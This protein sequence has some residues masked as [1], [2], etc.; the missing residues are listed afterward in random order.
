MQ[1]WFHHLRRLLLRAAGMPYLPA[2]SRRQR[3]RPKVEALEERWVPS[4]CSLPSLYI[5]LPA[6]IGP[7]GTGASKG[8]TITITYDMVYAAALNQ[9]FGEYLKGLKGVNGAGGQLVLNPGSATNPDPNETTV[10]VQVSRHGSDIEL[11]LDRN[12]QLGQSPQYAVLK[13]VKA[14]L[15]PPKPPPKACPTHHGE[16]E[17]CRPQHFGFGVGGIGGIGF[18]GLGGFGGGGFGGAGLGNFGS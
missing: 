5:K 18:G 13:G 17:S 2:G 14:C 6:G 7:S 3:L 10:H 4:N 11:K 12:V 9:G 16:R 15:E 1:S 8:N